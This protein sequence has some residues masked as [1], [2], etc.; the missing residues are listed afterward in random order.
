MSIT[1]MKPR[2]EMERWKSEDAPEKI[3]GRPLRCVQNAYKIM[4]TCEKTNNINTGARNVT[5]SFIPRKFR[6]IRKNKIPNSAGHLKAI[7]WAGKKD[8]SASHPEATE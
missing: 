4:K 2:L 8:H 5:D 6:T 7:Q 1:G 3:W